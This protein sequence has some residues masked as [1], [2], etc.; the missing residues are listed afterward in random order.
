LIYWVF[1]SLGN[2]VSPTVIT[3]ARHTLVTHGP[4]RWVRHPLYTTGMLSYL[5]FALLAEIWLIFLIAVP[6]FIVLAVRTSKEEARL[7]ER[8]GEDYRGYMRRTGR[9]LPRLQT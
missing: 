2:N 5:S 3:R 8:F 9:F 7:V 6:A 1:S 4:Y